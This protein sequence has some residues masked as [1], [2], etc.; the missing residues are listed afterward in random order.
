MVLLEG[1]SCSRSAPLS[2]L[3]AAGG[4]DDPHHDGAVH[5][6]PGSGR[7]NPCKQ[8]L[9][10][11]TGTD[12]LSGHPPNPF[13]YGRGYP[14]PTV[15][16]LE[17]VPESG[18]QQ[19]GAHCGPAGGRR[20]LPDPLPLPWLPAAGG[21]DDPHHDGAEHLHPGPRPLP[22][23]AILTARAPERAQDGAGAGGRTQPPA[24]AGR[25]QGPPRSPTEA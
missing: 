8:R 1:G 3:P 2:W 21:G 6:H 14:G 5:P 23:A 12:R 24:R 22:E 25:P 13:D 9:C 16:L 7:V 19:A 18:T 10:P 11:Y 4:G 20:G 17:N 15:I